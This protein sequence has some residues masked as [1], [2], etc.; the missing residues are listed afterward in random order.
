M[1][2]TDSAIIQMRRV[3]LRAATALRE[4]GTIPPGVDDPSIFRVRSGTAVLPKIGSWIDEVRSAL[5]VDSPEP[6]LSVQRP[7]NA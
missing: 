3:M 7:P 1:G 4:S 5:T 2:T 6:V